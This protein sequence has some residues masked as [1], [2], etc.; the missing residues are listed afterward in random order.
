MA[1]GKVFCG[2]SMFHKVTNASKL[3]MLNLVN[4]VKSEHALFIDC[5]MQNSHLA[6]LGCVEVSREQFLL[7]LKQQNTDNFSRTLWQPRYLKA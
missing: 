3:A 5:Q 1:V 7:Q 2:E 6:S 4:L